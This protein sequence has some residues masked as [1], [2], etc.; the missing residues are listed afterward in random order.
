MARWLDEGGL[1]EFSRTRGRSASR[2]ARDRA[3][4]AEEFG[5]RKFLIRTAHSSGRA[6]VA[7]LGMPR[8]RRDSEIVWIEEARRPCRAPL[9]SEFPTVSQSERG[10]Q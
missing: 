8:I 7:G 6:N 5:S 1:A 2:A 10:E 4:S 9:T 3:T